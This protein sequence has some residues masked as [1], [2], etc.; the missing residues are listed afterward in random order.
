[1]KYDNIKIL[2]FLDNPYPYIK[3]SVATVLTSLS[4][5]FSLALAESVLLDT[6]IISTNVGIAD[7][8]VKKYDCGTIIN[9]DER[10][11]ADVILEYLKKYDENI[12][13]KHFFI[14]NEFDIKTELE[15]TIQV[16][17]KTIEKGEQK[18]K[19][20]KLPYPVEKIDYYD[21]DNYVIKENL[22]YILEVKKDNVK[23]E[24]LINRK[25]DNNK[26]IVF[27]NGAIAGGN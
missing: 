12:E 22:L 27:N 18:T 2:G 26:L 19:I 3:N 17:D 6:P 5:G 24:Y 1:M 11:L 16:I 15:K 14:G 9:Y 10:E 20:K 7:E 4:E 13:K 25:K 23:Y 8:L 21:L